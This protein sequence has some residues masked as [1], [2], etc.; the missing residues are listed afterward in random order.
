MKTFAYIVIAFWLIAMYFLLSSVLVKA[1]LTPNLLSNDFTDGSWTGTNLTSTHGN[2]VIAG[3]HGQYVES[4]ISLTD[5]LNPI[6]FNNG[7]ESRQSGDIWIWNENSQSVLLKTTII[8]NS[9]NTITQ[10]KEISGSCEQYNGC[11]YNSSGDNTI[12][13]NKNTISESDYEIT[14]RFSFSVPGNQS[15]HTGADLKNPSLI[16]SYTQPD[17]YN[18]DNTFNTIEEIQ[19]EDDVFEEFYFDEIEEEFL[20]TSPTMNFELQ[21]DYIMEYE[22]YVIEYDDFETE[23][24][25][26][27]EYEMLPQNE[28]LSDEIDTFYSA[29]ELNYTENEDFETDEFYEEFYEEEYEEESLDEEIPNSD[30]ELTDNDNSEPEP[31]QEMELTEDEIEEGQI[32]EKPIESKTEIKEDAVEVTETVVEKKVGIK[33][34]KIT[35][36]DFMKLEAELKI[37]TMVSD[38][39]DEF[40]TPTIFY[41][42]QTLYELQPAIFDNREIYKNITFIA[43]DPLVVYETRLRNNRNIQNQ[44]RAELERMTWKN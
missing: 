2:N 39:V 37:N 13:I 25:M 21:Q 38:K 27:S 4:T 15:G 7:F 22:D 11:G 19:W 40:F 8:S 29:E 32:E 12:I 36:F 10:T 1:E 35:K 41:P 26:E 18:L 5:S 3:I 6:E 24:E 14:S 34:I 28:M 17:F 16:I 44:Q 30:S 31:E 43:A 9:G 33:K 42:K 20:F 23:F